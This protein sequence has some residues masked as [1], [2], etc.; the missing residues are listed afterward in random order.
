MLSKKH[1]LKGDGHGNG[2]CKKACKSVFLPVLSAQLMT[3][4]TGRPRAMRN[5]PPAE[6]PLPYQTKQTS[7]KTKQTLNNHRHHFDSVN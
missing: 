3:A 2:V 1:Y 7:V 4:P 5:F 6:P